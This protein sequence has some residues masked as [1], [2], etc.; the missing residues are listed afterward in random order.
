MRAAGIGNNRESACR[1]EFVPG[2][3]IHR[4]SYGDSCGVGARWLLTG[5][6]FPLG[7]ERRAV[8]IGPR[9]N[10]FYEVVTW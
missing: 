4:P 10:A 9:R 2:F 1:G 5:G 6:D 3:T 8:F 7:N